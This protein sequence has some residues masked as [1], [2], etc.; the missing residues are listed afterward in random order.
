MRGLSTCRP[1]RCRGWLQ[2]R[3]KAA[4][5]RRRPAL[6]TPRASLHRALLQARI[7]Q[8]NLTGDEFHHRWLGWASKGASWVRQQGRRFS[9][10]WDRL[11]RVQ[12]ACSRHAAGAR[13]R[14]TPFD[15]LGSRV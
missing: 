13:C 9:L 10:S 15:P 2:G 5:E 8:R 11:S 4:E 12:T 1:A 14:V 7:G 3:P 6:T